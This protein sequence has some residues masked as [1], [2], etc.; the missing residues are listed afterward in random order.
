MT[1]GTSL[2]IAEHVTPFGMSWGEDDSLLFGGP[3][4]LTRM[5][6]SGGTPE[7]LTTIDPKKSETVPRWP[8]HLPGGRAAIFS[9]ANGTSS[10]IF[11]IDLKTHKARE[12]IAGSEGRYVPPGYLVFFRSSTIFAAACTIRSRTAGMDSGLCSPAGAPGFGISTRRA[13]SGR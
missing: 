4:G 11:V 5:P 6:S 1:G 3:K 8:S 9:T 10:Q 12:L 7:N 13:G 2:T